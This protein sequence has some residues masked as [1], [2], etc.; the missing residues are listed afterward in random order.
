MREEGRR[1]GEKR[2]EERRERMNEYPVIIDISCF[3][4]GIPER[5]RIKRTREKRQSARN[6]SAIDWERKKEKKIK[7]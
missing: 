6:G 1:R 7:K 4:I 3:E 2:K 5:D